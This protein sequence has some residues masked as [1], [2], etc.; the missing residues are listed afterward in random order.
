MDRIACASVVTKKSLAEFRLLDYSISQYHDT[1]WYLSVDP[2]VYDYFKESDKHFCI[3]NIESDENANHCGEDSNP[4]SKKRFMH[5]MKTKAFA[6]NKALEMGEKFVMFLDSDI[7]FVHSIEKRLLD[8]FKNSDIDAFLCPH[9]TFNHQNEAN[10]GF[11]NA[12][13][14]CTS[15]RNFLNTWI[16]I[17][18]KA[19]DF[20]LYGDQKPLELIYFN[21]LTMNIPI[22]YDIGFWRMNERNNLHASRVN[23][24]GVDNN[25]NILFCNLPAICF[26]AHTFKDLGYTNY[27]SFMVERVLHL[28]RVTDRKEHKNI[29]DFM[30]KLSMENI[31]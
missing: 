15:S 8:L 9:S 30:S 11:F 18:E 1:Q 24:L 29:L 6:C 23:S 13:M 22:N 3:Q 25:K 26:H 7:F 19:L 16:D 14:Y 17:N 21:F 12:G 31:S 10:V 28:M 5:I 27:G 2:I 4:E 20:G